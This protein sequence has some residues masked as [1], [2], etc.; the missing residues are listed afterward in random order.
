MDR[1]QE[2]TF[3]TLSVIGFFAMFGGIYLHSHG[4]EK[5]GYLLIK[6]SLISMTIGIILTGDKILS[7]FLATCV[8]TVFKQKENFLGTVNSKGT[9]HDN[10]K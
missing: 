9:N 4:D 3:L 7:V 10:D 5:I 6:A 8:Y 1:W 2:V